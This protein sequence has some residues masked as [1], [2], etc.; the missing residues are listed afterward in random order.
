MGVGLLLCIH[1]RYLKRFLL[2]YQSFLINMTVTV[3]VFVESSFFLF[4]FFIF[5]NLLI[6]RPIFHMLHIVLYHSYK[7]GHPNITQ[8]LN[9]IRDTM[10]WNAI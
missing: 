4:S 9:I 10:Y 2:I 8:S 6:L 7:I 1:S 5:F 3:L